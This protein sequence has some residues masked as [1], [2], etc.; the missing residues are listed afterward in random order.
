MSVYILLITTSVK[1][2]L[3]FIVYTFKPLA[4][5]MT[6]EALCRLLES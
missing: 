1:F 5:I 6:R 3:G 4:T 2:I